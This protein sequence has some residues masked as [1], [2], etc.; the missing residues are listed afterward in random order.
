[1]CFDPAGLLSLPADVIDVGE[2]M[3]GGTDHTVVPR[4][5]GH[6]TWRNEI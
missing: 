3:L 2:A 4:S 1:M 5:L 6:E